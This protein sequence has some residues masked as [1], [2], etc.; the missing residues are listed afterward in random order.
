[1]RI[2]LT[3]FALLVAPALAAA[4]SGVQ[5]T[6]QRD[7]TLVS[8]DVASERWAITY[9]LSDG[10]VTGNVFRT[11]GGP[12]AFLDCDRTSVTDTDVMF[13]CFGAD[14][15]GAAPCPTSQ[16]TLISSGISLPLSFFFPPGDSPSDGGGT[17]ADLLG[18]W[19]FTVDSGNGQDTFTYDFDHLENNN[20]DAAGKEEGSGDDIVASPSGSDFVMFDKQDLNCRKY[21]FHFVG[22]DRL[23]GTQ[24]F[25]V[26]VPFTS[27]CDTFDVGDTHSFFAQRMG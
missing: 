12:P 20:Q 8:K 1:M 3:V 22:H 9:R 25:T 10:H 27:D 18:T 5:W 17:V 6:R 15:C 16:Y 14:A 19:Q 2:L 7:A 11:D 23:E 4:Q 24:S 13:D 26:R 21:V